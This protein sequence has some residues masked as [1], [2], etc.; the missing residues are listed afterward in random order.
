MLYTLPLARLIDEFQKLPGIGPKTAQ[1]LAFHVINKNETDVL[2]FSQAL[3][4]AKQHIRRCDTCFNLTCQNTCEICENPHRDRVTLCV[5]AEARDL[6]AVEKTGEFKGLY[7][8][9]GGLIS[10]ID[11]MGPEQLKIESLMQ[12]LSHPETLI[13]EV[14]L[15]LPP[16]IEG[17]TTSLYIT[18]LIKPFSK[19]MSRIAFG[20]PVGGELEYADALTLS[21]AMNAR[22]AV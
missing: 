20:L 16:S 11:G 15:A 10:P 22:V 18:R 7:H 4:E 8:I 12:R 9:L 19:T 5:V 13:Q 2:G 1:R 3:I 6:I 21:R 14:I 17:D